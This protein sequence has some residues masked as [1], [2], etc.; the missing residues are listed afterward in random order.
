MKIL[1]VGGTG[2][3]GGNAAIYLQQQGH[4][5]TLMARNKPTAPS[6]AV[7]SFITGNYIE[8]DC[9][10]G[11]LNGFDALVFAAAVDIRYFPFDGSVTEEEFYSKANTIAVPKFFAAARAAGIKRCVYL[12]SFYP[13]VAP[14]RIEK[15]AYVRSRHLTD[16]AVLAMSTADFVVCTLNAPFI[17]GHLP[18][19]DIPHLGALVQYAKGQ[20]EAAPIFAPQ[21]GTNHIS[22]LSVSE[23]VL[24]G[25]LRG[26]S[27]K[28]Y[29]I[30]DE[31]YNWKDYLELWFAAAANPQDL[32]VKEDD[33]PMLPNAIMFAGAGATVS[34]EPDAAETALLGYGRNRIKALIE[35]VV[36]SY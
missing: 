5:V 27:G 32:P 15:C 21:G 4:D 8:D 7:F 20:L 22:S 19:L 23:A 2:M 13:T 16:Q 6:L 28:A 34:F 12:G 35:E 1:L 36:S 14:E 24:G 30:G 18:G 33:H 9:S 3:V 26:E 11:R 25:L 31:N 10:D 17:L 29:L